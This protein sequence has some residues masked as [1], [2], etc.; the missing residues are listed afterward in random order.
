MTKVL[1]ALYASMICEKGKTTMALSRKVTKT[2]LE[3]T[4]HTLEVFAETDI[5]A[6]LQEAIERSRALEQ[7]LHDAYSEYENLVS[8]VSDRASQVRKRA[9]DIAGK[10]SVSSHSKQEDVIQG[11]EYQDIALSL[12]MLV[13][14]NSIETLSTMKSIF[15]PKPSLAG[16]LEDAQKRP[17]SLLTKRALPD[18][19]MSLAN[20]FLGILPGASP[21]LSIVEILMVAKDTI[22]A[23][24]ID[25]KENLLS[26]RRIVGC[27]WLIELLDG[28]GLDKI[29]EYL[30]RRQVQVKEILEEIENLAT[31][32]EDLVKKAA[33]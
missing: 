23:R 27:L 24:K 21:F 19:T 30:K 26:L 17:I 11:N 3:G 31:D 25:H 12:E 32:I 14:N 20:I 8:S 33:L 4:I 29:K 28:G 2:D 18:L 13:L 1:L 15:N 16:Q 6:L 9:I 10:L 5:V 7:A 22:N